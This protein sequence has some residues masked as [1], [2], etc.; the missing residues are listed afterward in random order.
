[1]DRTVRMD[2]TRG[3]A[4]AAIGD[5]LVARARFEQAEHENPRQTIAEAREALDRAL[6]IDAALVP[7]IKYRIELA[8][9][10]AE[11]LLADH[12]DPAATVT[13][14][15]ADAQQLLLRRPEDGFAHLLSCRAELLA[16]RSAIAR[17][18]A[19]DTFLARAA[20]EAAHAREADPMDASAWTACAEVEQL[21]AASAARSSRAA[22][23]A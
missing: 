23:V 5:V 13:A 7:P 1:F 11:A 10:E 3:D 14:M 18:A 9:L 8:E 19:S 16:A 2:A 6:A 22:S 17:G 12:A 20:A 21:R 4:L 15:R